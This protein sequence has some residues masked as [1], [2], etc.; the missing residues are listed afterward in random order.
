[1]LSCRNKGNPKFQAYAHFIKPLRDRTEIIASIS[2]NAMSNTTYYWLIFAVYFIVSSGGLST[3]AIFIVKTNA[4]AWRLRSQSFG[5]LK[6]R[7]RNSFS[8]PHMLKNIGIALW[9]T[10]LVAVNIYPKVLS[11][12]SLVLF[13]G[14]IEWTI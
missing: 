10:W 9:A 13:I 4:E 2:P 14:F 5:D 12:I 1:M 7:W 8:P 11:T 6:N 3:L